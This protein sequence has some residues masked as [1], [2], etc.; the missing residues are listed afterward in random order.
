MNE[1]KQVIE[2]PKSSVPPSVRGRSTV[3]L[4]YGCAQ[5]DQ[6]PTLLYS[7]LSIT[8]LG[9]ELEKGPEM[10]PGWALEMNLGYETVGAQQAR[11]R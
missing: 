5:M 7:Y 10:A 8:R 11:A 2:D 3:H 9:L 6:V 1:T 4:A